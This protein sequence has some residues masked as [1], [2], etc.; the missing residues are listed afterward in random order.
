MVRDVMRN[1]IGSLYWVITHLCDS[2]CSHCYMSCGPGGQSLTED[3]AAA[4]I[5]NL[6]RRINQ[7]IILSGGE[8]LHPGIR[9]LLYFITEELLRKYGKRH[10]AIQTNGEFLDEA[11]IDECLEAGI[12]HI[13]IASID[14]HHKN[15]HGSLEEKERYFREILKG[16]GLKELPS[17]SELTPENV[18]K[19]A[20]LGNIIKMVA[21][22]F[23]RQ[24][25]FSIW[26]A[27]EDIWLGGNWA[28]GRALKNGNVLMDPAHNFCR[29]WSGGLNFLK[30]GSP[31][32][33]VVIQLSYLYPCCPSTR[34]FIADVRYETLIAGLEK[35]A[36]EPI[37]RAINRGRPYNGAKQFNMQPA[38]ARKRLKEV[39][40][41]CILCDEL[42]MKL[43][44][45]KFPRSPFKI[46]L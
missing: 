7:N 30:S 44:E 46:Y 4:I 14:K 10:I 17:V 5:D 42:L 24:P 34:V 16:K 35:A 31:R 1:E 26:G 18:E 43:D 19:N 36:A 23:Y 45:D 22:H 20:R 33:E 2:T 40:N 29:L 3:E 38:Q 39:K 8:V 32:Q 21:P 25:N 41:I 37:F 13:S 9:T 27:N 6:P 12:T 15:R 28:R 11:V